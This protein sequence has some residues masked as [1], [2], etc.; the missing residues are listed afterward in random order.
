M[1]FR[2]KIKREGKQGKG[3]STADFLLRLRKKKQQSTLYCAK[4]QVFPVTPPPQQ[5]KGTHREPCIGHRFF[6]TTSLGLGSLTLNKETY[7]LY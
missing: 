6:I 1:I 3:H 7:S 2:L 5:E 4:F